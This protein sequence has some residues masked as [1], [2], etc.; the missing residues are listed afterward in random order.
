MFYPSQASAAEQHGTSGASTTSA[1]T[2][3]LKP[4]S[5]AVPQRIETAQ[6]FFGWYEELEA[7]KEEEAEESFRAYAPPSLLPS[8]QYPQFFSN[9][10]HSSIRPPPFPALI[11]QHRQP[12]CGTTILCRRNHLL[13]S[14]LAGNF[15]GHHFCSRHRRLPCGPRCFTIGGSG[16][17]SGSGSGRG[18]VAVPLLL[19]TMMLLLP[20]H[21]VPP[22]LRCGR[23]AMR[24]S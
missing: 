20:L 4:Q 22:R 3:Q 10:P 23:A 11:S 18:V 14:M 6:Q 24:P 16:G 19:L 12:R 2:R 1:D 17:C 9:L 21:P 15:H 13:Y 8:V 5:P 7:R